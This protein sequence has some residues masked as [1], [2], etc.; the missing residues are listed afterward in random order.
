M[1]RTIIEIRDEILAAKAAQASL[2]TLNST[3]HVSIYRLW[4]WITATCIWTLEK[5]FDIFKVEVDD[6]ISK[7]N[8]HTPEWYVE[9]AKAFQYG[10]NLVAEKDYYDNTGIDDTVIA[11]SKIVKFAAMPEIPFLRLKVAKLVGLNLAALS[12]PELASFQAYI[13]RIKGAGVTEQCNHY[14]HSTG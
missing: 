5:L 2:N 8:P 7:K 12:A 1:A 3:S 9:K 4:I 14:Q 11:A 13:K 10:Y 6:T